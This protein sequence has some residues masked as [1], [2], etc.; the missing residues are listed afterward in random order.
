MAV[1]GT[2]A[3]A[4]RFAERKIFFWLHPPFALEFASRKTV[5]NGCERPQSLNTQLKQGVNEI[6]RLCT[7]RYAPVKAMRKPRRVIV[8]GFEN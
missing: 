7:K 2:T 1:V 4:W 5:E 6:I 8:T 3:R